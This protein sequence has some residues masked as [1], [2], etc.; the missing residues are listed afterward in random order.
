ML[1]V[2][3]WEN[4]SIEFASDT[5]KF[6]VLRDRAFFGTKQSMQKEVIKNIVSVKKFICIY[7]VASYCYFNGNLKKLKFKLRAGTCVWGRAA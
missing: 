6:K 2:I 7:Y 3:T 4:K 1:S 5:T